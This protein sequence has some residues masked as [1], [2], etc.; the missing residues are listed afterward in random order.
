MNKMDMKCIL[1]LANYDIPAHNRS[2]ISFL[3]TLP[4]IQI[5]EEDTLS[6]FVLISMLE[7]SSILFQ[8]HVWAKSDGSC[9]TEKFSASCSGH[10]HSRGSCEVLSGAQCRRQL[11]ACHQLYCPY[12][13]AG[14][15][16]HG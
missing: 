14:I 3:N 2:F 16:S 9:P 4:V 13:L 7:R 10:Y 8:V 1:L 15:W 6:L 11:D 5:F 12:A